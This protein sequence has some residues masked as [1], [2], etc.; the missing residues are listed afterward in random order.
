[1]KVLHGSKVKFGLVRGIA[2]RAARSVELANRADELLEE[3]SDHF[4]RHPIAFGKTFKGA[5]FFDF[6]QV[7][8]SA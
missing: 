7:F 6:H 4:G 1:M 5:P 8:K 3:S 2:C